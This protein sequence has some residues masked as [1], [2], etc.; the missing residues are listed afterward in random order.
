MGPAAC[1][2]P[3]AYVVHVGE[4]AGKLAPQVAE[5]LRDAHLDVV[6]HAGGGGFKAQMKRADASGARFALVIGDDEAA[7]GVVGVKSLREDGEQHDVPVV[8]LAAHL[9]R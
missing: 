5:L 3:L 2:L 6:L 9:A 8:N 1:R 7:Q 4:A